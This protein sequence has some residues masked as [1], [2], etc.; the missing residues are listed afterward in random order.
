MYTEEDSIRIYYQDGPGT[1]KDWVGVYVEGE[2][3]NVDELDGF[4]YTYGATDGYVTIPKKT[5]KP[6]RYFCSLFINDSYD[7]VSERK[8]FTVDQ[9]S[10]ISD[11][12]TSDNGLCIRFREDGQIE[13]SGSASPVRVEL[14]NLAGRQGLLAYATGGHLD[15]LGALLGVERLAA[16]P[17]RTMLR[18]SLQEALTFSVT[19]PTNSL[20]R[21]ISE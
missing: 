21:S 12:A 16:K 1:P 7:E 20:L 3:P 14:I 2:D 11:A 6:G 8:Y 4:Y 5:L 17:A 18:Y 13:V 19:V 10:G 15:H 9:V